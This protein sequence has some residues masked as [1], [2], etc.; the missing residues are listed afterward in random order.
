MSARPG[1]SGGYHAS[2]IPT[3]ISN[4]PTKT[5][6]GSQSL[7]GEC[8]PISA[9]CSWWCKSGSFSRDMACELELLT[10]CERA[11]CET[12]DYLTQMRGETG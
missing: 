8:S 11:V 3:G 7:P 9:W 2:D 1:P 10:L 5:M 6:F 4:P 12:V